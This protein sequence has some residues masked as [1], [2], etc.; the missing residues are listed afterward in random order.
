MIKRRFNQFWIYFQNGHRQYLSWIMTFFN[1]VT[2]QYNLFLNKLLPEFEIPLLTFSLIFL[3]AYF[4]LAYTIGW[5]SFKKGPKYEEPAL[6]P[7]NQDFIRASIL[8]ARAIKE[9]FNGENVTARVLIDKAIEIRE[10][11]IRK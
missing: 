11:W 5:L 9:W 3:L 7:Y 4:P 10:N 8:E 1:F 6:S 2:I